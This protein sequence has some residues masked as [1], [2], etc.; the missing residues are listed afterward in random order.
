MRELHEDVLPMFFP[1]GAPRAADPVNAANAA[2]IRVAIAESINLSI[3]Q[4]PDSDR[5][6]ADSVNEFGKRID[7]LCAMRA[8]RDTASA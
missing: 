6:C 7:E 2:E 8:E 1:G 4:T 3:P 5:G